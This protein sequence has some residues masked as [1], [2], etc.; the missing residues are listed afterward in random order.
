[1]GVS[2]HLSYAFLLLESVPN[3]FTLMYVYSSYLRDTMQYIIKYNKSAS[4]VY[5]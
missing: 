5:I 3:Q 4:G 2:K 1:M